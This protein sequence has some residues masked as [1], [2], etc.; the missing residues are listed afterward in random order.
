M[1]YNLDDEE[2]YY[3]MGRTDSYKQLFKR[4]REGA[5]PTTQAL[6]PQLYLEYFEPH[7][8]AGNDILYIHFS[9]KMSGTFNYM[10]T[11]I[12]E[13][14]EKYPERKITTFNTKNI[15]WGGGFQVLEAAKLH[16]E[17]KSDEEVV[18]F[19]E[20]FSKHVNTNFVVENLTYLKR[21]GRLSS[22]SAFFGKLLNIKPILKVNLEGSIEKTK[23]ANGF[24][25]A[26]TMM[27]N[28]L[29]LNIDETEKYPIYLLD[30]DNEKMADFLEQ[31]L[32]EKL[33]KVKIE[34]YPI[35]PVICA[36]C[37]PGTVGVVYYGKQQV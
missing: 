21:G 36:H 23:T 3:D 26:L 34:R 24:K 14:K 18:A 28:E 22:T 4:M 13:L 19:L 25:S 8:K 11:A 20:E 12:D 37:G 7:L 10:K 29:T 30:A 16:A 15:C 27:A 32:K 31:L 1:P 9:D 35:G 5:T 6:N 17:G 2:S 33:P